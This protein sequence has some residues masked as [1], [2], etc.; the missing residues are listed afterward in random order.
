MKNIRLTYDEFFQFIWDDSNLSKIVSVAYQSENEEYIRS[1][2]FDIFRV[3]EFAN[4]SER[5]A[6]KLFEIHFSNLFRF[7]PKTKNIKE[8]KDNYTD[9]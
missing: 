7:Q 3:Y 6:L 5:V 8:I 9:Y 4:L 2:T 1:I